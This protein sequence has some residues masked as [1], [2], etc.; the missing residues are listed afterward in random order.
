MNPEVNDDYRGDEEDVWQRLSGLGLRGILAEADSLERERGFL[1][2]GK[3]SLAFDNYQSFIAAAECG[4]KVENRVEAAA[5]RAAAAA[6]LLPSLKEA[7]LKFESDS[8]LLLERRKRLSLI[9]SKHTSLLEILELPQLAETAIRNGQ[10]D[11]ALRL[12][13]FTGKL[14]KKLGHIPLLGVVVAA[15][16]VL[17]QSMVNQLISSLKTAIQ[18]P[19]CLRFHFFPELR[20]PL[21][22]I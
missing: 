19:A 22:R 8:S 14:D 17:C 15:V 12:K 9:L 5:D 10:Y 16:G 20:L 2:D 1:A 3:R 4:K 11:Q 7:C 21:G 18:L 6:T 13:S